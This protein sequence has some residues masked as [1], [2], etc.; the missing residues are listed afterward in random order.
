[1]RLI[2]FCILAAISGNLIMIGAPAEEDAATAGKKWLSLVDDQKYEGSWNEAS[3]MF[4]SEV[5]Q[6]QWVAALKRSREP[7]GPLVSRTPS[8]VQ[9][10]KFLRGAPDGDYAIIHFTTS[11]TGKSATERL[12]LVKEDGRWQMFAYG[13]Y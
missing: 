13:I 9:F 3:S 1:L 4:R 10:S 2:L 11:F 6:E 8:R 5:T 12:T 7:L